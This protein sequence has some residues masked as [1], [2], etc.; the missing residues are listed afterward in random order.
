[1]GW[2][3]GPGRMSGNL[4]RR[5]APSCR[6]RPRSAKLWSSPNDEGSRT[7][8]IY[9]EGQKQHW[10]RVHF[11]VSNISGGK[12]HWLLFLL[13]KTTLQGHLSLP[14][15]KQARL[16][17]N[18]SLIQNRSLNAKETVFALTFFY[19]KNVHTSLTLLRSYKCILCRSWV[20]ET[21][22]IF[23]LLVAWTGWIMSYY[24]VVIEGIH[25]NNF[26]ST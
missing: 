6:W 12:V 20:C 7:D 26:S 19:M 8:G 17:G 1:M 9:W 16:R 22:S 21:L 4:H 15:G 14:N 10:Q 5:C 24:S 13:S 18:H 23:R 3:S 2:Q 25:K 11:I